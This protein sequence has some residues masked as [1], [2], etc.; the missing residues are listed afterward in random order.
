MSH[1]DDVLTQ[2]ANLKFV[3]KAMKQPL[4]SQSY[5]KKITKLW[6]K[7]KMLNHCIDL[8]IHMRS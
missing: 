5:E 2:K 3:S 6:S 4:L 7:K 8:L 1:L